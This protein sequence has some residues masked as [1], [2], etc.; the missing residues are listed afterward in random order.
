MHSDYIRAGNYDRPYPIAGIPVMLLEDDEG[1]FLHDM[2]LVREQVVEENENPEVDSNVLACREMEEWIDHHA[3]DP[4]ES[5][6]HTLLYQ[7]NQLK[8]QL[9]IAMDNN[10]IFPGSTTM[11]FLMSISHLN[12][13][14]IRPMKNSLKK[15]GNFANG[16]GFINRR[17]KL[18]ILR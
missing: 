17:S 1:D 5:I 3:D 16:I 9:G 15:V 7:S 18:T 6:H 8:A 2:I 11:I 4:I 10:I 14:Q 12:Q 13:I